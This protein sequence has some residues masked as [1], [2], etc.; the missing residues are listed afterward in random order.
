MLAISCL[1]LQLRQLLR[2][3]RQLRGLLQRL[4]P[5]RQQ[6][7]QCPCGSMGCAA[8][9]GFAACL[10]ASVLIS[11]ALHKQADKVQAGEVQLQPA[12]QFST[13]LTITSGLQP[14]DAAGQT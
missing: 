5:T 12:P 8:Q 3:R 11:R 9:W 13:H 4:Q 14:H 6:S 2:H 10:G 7:P 1:Y